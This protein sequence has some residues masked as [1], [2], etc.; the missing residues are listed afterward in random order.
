MDRKSLIR[1]VI[2]KCVTDKY[3]ITI[4]VMV[5]SKKEYSVVKDYPHIYY[6]TIFIL[7]V[8]GEF[9]GPTYLKIREDVKFILYGILNEREHLKGIWRSTIV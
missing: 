8:P 4:D 7:N 2:K 6:Y 5:E 1:E 3:P 9:C